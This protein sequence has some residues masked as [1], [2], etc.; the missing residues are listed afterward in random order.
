MCA[1]KRELPIVVNPCPEDHNTEREKMKL[2]LADI[3][4][5]NKGLKHRIFKAI[6]KGEIDGFSIK[7]RY[8]DAGEIEDT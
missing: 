4:R 3:E 8:P 2:L 7:G 1:R 6:C 5:D